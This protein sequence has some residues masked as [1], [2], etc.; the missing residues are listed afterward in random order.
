MEIFIIY[1][2]F[3]DIEQLVSLFVSSSWPQ[4]VCMHHFY[5]HKPLINKNMCLR[6]LI[7][8]TLMLTWYNT[9]SWTNLITK[10]RTYCPK[11]AI[12]QVIDQM[13]RTLAHVS[14]SMGWI[15]CFH[16][17]WFFEIVDFRQRAYQATNWPAY[18]TSIFKV[19]Y[20]ALLW[21]FESCENQ[22]R[23]IDF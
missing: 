14:L 6:A 20:L 1:W 21:W 12:N 13:V 17:R 9:S 22:T 7:I 5:S 4:L 18:L 2:K 11:V 15:P 10:W 19:I 3:F 23:A 16:L 8:E